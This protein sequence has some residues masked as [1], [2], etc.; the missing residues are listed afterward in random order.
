MTDEVSSSDQP[1][2]ILLI[3]DDEDDYILTRHVLMSFSA[4]STRID[5]VS[6][7]TEA[8]GALARNEHAVC[9][10]DY[11]L[12]ADNGVDLLQ[13][14][15]AAGSDVPVILLTGQGSRFI[16]VEAMK[17]GAVYY[18]DKNRLN[19]IDLE[20]AI[21]YSIER[22]QML[23]LVQQT[24]AR[25]EQRVARRTTELRRVNSELEMEIEQRKGAEQR[26][27]EALEN[28]R[29]LNRLKTEFITTMSHEFRTP[30]AVIQS[31]TDILRLY[32]AR[33]TGEQR[34]ARYQQIS[35]QVRWMIG[36]LDNLLTVR[37]AEAGTIIVSRNQIDLDDFCQTL[38]DSLTPTI[39]PGQQL[40]Y[41]TDGRRARALLDESLLRQIL[42]NLLTN[43]IKFTPHGGHI[44]L[45]L[46]STDQE[47]AL[48]VSDEGIGI[49]ADD[50]PHIFETFRRASNVDNIGGTGLG[51]SIVWNSVE[52]LGGTVGVDSQ[53]GAGSTFTVRLPLPDGQR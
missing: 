29:E 30:L 20:R 43:A 8:L 4:P 1:L 10:M 51:L 13:Q 3:D 40:S 24:N 44:R 12:G 45:R 27:L 21:R 35:A 41:E 14:A 50:L 22:A 31:S 7:Y 25:L 48:V 17:V 49:P 28:E 15:R 47:A 23:R 36:L 9:L 19:E 34:Q 11:Y 16:D 52:L 53:P 46:S 39:F 2:S 26:L 18:L 42:Y 37:K 38:V 32:E 33:T 5:W 6:S